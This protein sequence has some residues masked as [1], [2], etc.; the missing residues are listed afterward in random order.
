VVS[1]D[2]FLPKPASRIVFVGVVEIFVM[3]V[4]VVQAVMV[5][6]VEVAVVEVVVVVV[7]LMTETEEVSILACV[8]EEG[9]LDNS[10]KEEDIRI[11]DNNMVGIG[12]YEGEVEGRGHQGNRHHDHHHRQRGWRTL[13]V[14]LLEQTVG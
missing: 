3:F 8:E 7:M 9:T 6:F 1:V 5:V 11:D 2:R 12:A 10:H 14:H 13:W 4:V